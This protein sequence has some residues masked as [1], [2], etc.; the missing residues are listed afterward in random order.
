[1]S[2]KHKSG[3]SVDVITSRQNPIISMTAKLGDKKHRDA[4]GLF[5]LDGIKLTLE[6]ASS[7]LTVEYVIIR[8]D[9]KDLYYETVR[10]VLPDAKIYVV[11]PSAFDRVTD[12]KAPQGVVTAVRYSDSVKRDGDVDASLLS[13]VSLFFDGV[14]NPDN[15]GAILRSARAFGV[16]NVIC[17]NGCADIYSRRVMRA[18][19]GAALHIGS[20]YVSDTAATCRRLAAEGRRIIAT[21]PSPTASSLFEFSFRDGDVIVIGNEGHGISD[22]VIAESTDMLYIPMAEGQESL[23]AASAAAVILYEAY[24]QKH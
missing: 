12:E 20:T 6:A 11:S 19:M 5:L 24:R 3:G 16:E 18:S 22:A 23:N 10:G 17:G 2:E 21:L 13:G 4:E 7:P 9:A 1:M 15:F 8:E 14:Q